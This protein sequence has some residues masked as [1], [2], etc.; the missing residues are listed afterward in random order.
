[1][2]SKVRIPSSPPMKK[3][4]SVWEIYWRT[5]QWAFIVLLGLF[6]FFLQYLSETILDWIDVNY[7]D[8]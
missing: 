6:A 4:F 2:P 5:A 1:M 3:E 7:F 8:R